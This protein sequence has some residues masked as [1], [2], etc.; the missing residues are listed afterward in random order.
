[1]TESLLTV[2]HLAKQGKVKQQTLDWLSNAVN[3]NGILQ[4]IKKTEHQSAAI[5]MKHQAFMR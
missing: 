3:T 5:S 1:M 2:Y 4:N